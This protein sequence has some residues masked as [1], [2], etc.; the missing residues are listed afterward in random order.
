[1][2]REAR[3]PQVENSSSFEEFTRNAHL[4]IERLRQTGQP[5]VLTVNGLPQVVVQSADAYQKLLDEIEDLQ[6]IRT[7][8]E[9]Y[10]EAKRGEGRPARD[11]V[12]EIA[13]RHAIQL[14]K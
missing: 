10:Q 7:L 13:G 2:L 1:M 5:Q 14:P 11:V 6:S 12:R 9:S 3:M 8:R 4:H